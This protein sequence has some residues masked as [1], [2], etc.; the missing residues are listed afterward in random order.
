MFFL[1]LF[2]QDAGLRQLWVVL[3]YLE[4]EVPEGLPLLVLVP[5]QVQPDCFDVLQEALNPAINVTV[6]GLRVV[7]QH[8][9]SLHI[10][11]FCEVPAVGWS[12][13]VQEVPVFIL[14]LLFLFFLFGLV[15]VLAPL[16]VQVMVDMLLHI[17]LD[18]YVAFLLVAL[19]QDVVFDVLEHV[20]VYVPEFLGRFQPLLLVI[21]IE[22][23]VP[24]PHSL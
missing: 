19:Q 3:E 12:H 22:V 8:V 2:G 18:P 24:Y 20:R 23:A 15:L 9:G 4:G 7:P 14:Y 11:I 1:G 6:L 16:L 5:L 17:I 13:L 21:H 10:T